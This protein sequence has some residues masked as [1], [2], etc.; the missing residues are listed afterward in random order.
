[1]NGF[2]QIKRIFVILIL[3]LIGI[4]GYSYWDKIQP[5]YEEGKEKVDEI[6]GLVEKAE[7]IK[8][9]FSEIDYKSIYVI[10]DDEEYELLVEVVESEEDRQKGLMYRESL[11][12]DCGML[13]VFPENTQ[14]GFWM[15][16]CLI[17][18]DIIFI[19]ESGVITDIKENFE[20]CD[21]TVCESYDPKTEYRYAI[22]VD[23]GW[24][25]QHGISIGDRVAG[26]KSDS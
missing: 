24:T 3:I 26:L 7:D 25:S 8:D 9:S 17:P 15:K 6:L 12:E 2:R 5:A 19:T 21:D 23:A 11:C 16:D 13:F 1:M 10:T 4:V 18:L 22:E 20:P 14:M